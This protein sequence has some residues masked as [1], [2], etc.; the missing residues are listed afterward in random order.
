MRQ[1]ED[2]EGGKD[3]KRLLRQC[4][5]AVRTL[6][7][8][9]DVILFGSRA[10]SEATADSDYD[11]LVLLPNE[12]DGHTERRIEASIYRIEREAGVVISVQFYPRTLWDSPRLRVTPFRRHIDRDGVTL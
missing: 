2:W 7:P 4:K 9:A 1:I 5:K 8:E 3:D 10:R 12:H 11:L 6:A